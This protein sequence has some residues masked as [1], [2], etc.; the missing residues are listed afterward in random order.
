MKF[1]LDWL[2][3]PLETTASLEAI[4]EKL[5]AIGLEVESIE[6]KAKLL[7]PFTVAYVKEAKQH[8]DADRLR[9]CTVETGTEDLQIVCG[10]PNARAGIK[11][12]LSRPGDYIPGLDK[13]ISLGK[14]RGVESQG[15][16]C[17]ADE[18]GLGDDHDGIL[19][20]PADAPIGAKLLDVLA[21]IFPAAGTV[22]I[23]INLT[24]N[25]G[26]CAGV[27][28]IARDLAAAGLGKLKPL[29]STTVPAA[30]DNPYNVVVEDDADC[31]AIALRLI[32]GVKNIPSPSWLRSWLEAIGVTP[33]SALVDITNFLTFDL[34]RPLHVFD[35]AKVHGKTVIIRRAK[36]GESLEALN[37][38]TY[39][40]TPEMLVIADEQGVESLAGVMGGLASGCSENTTEVLVECALFNPERVAIAGRL[41]QINSD[42]R[43]RFERGVDPAS[44][45]YG[46]EI[47][48]RMILDICG[49][50]ASSIV[51]V[52]KADRNRDA[53]AYAPARF[54]KLTGVELAD[55]KQQ[56]VFEKLGCTVI[57]KGDS[58]QI[59]PPSW[60]PDITIPEDLIE[61]GLRIY[62]YDQIPAMP[63]PPVTSGT[64]LSPIQRR[65]A[66]ARRVATTQGLSECVTWSFMP[67]ALAAEFAPANPALAL[68]NPISVELSQ[69][70][71]SIVG[72]LLQTAARNA[73]H[74]QSDVA[75]FEVGPIYNQLGLDGQETVATGLRIG[76]TIPASW[77]MQA[78]PATLFTVKADLAALLEANGLSLD[79]VPLNRE[80]PSYY[81]PGRSFALRLGP[82]VI[83]YA[84][85]LHPRLVASQ[86]LK[87]AVAFELFL[88]RLPLPKK[89][90]AA[91][92]MLKLP[93]LQAVTRDFAFLVPADAPADALLK[94]IR[95]A[96]KDVITNVTLFDIYQDEARLPGQKSLTLTVTL[97]PRGDAAFTDKDLEAFSQKIVAAAE[98]TGAK[99]RS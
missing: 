29:P 66:L 1:T 49:G 30:F 83:A 11:V 34:A 2:K 50:E 9:V 67:P 45:T 46:M 97:Q 71:P 59:T 78:R 75:L 15:M 26:D 37:N 81:H 40:L 44:L 35:A 28:G 55:E 57:A 14:I 92:L 16:L 32:R 47:A 77:R 63:L 7:A 20:L 22:V 31:P 94:A 69:M 62:G 87:S 38:K 21:D 6:D 61:E 54:A 18:L 33:I 68:V 25:R 19:E 27:Y 70:R 95:K 85:E 42:A 41:L 82:T 84:G 64:A 60:R 86:D 48:T 58:W 13:T 93:V 65:T 43:Y 39:P 99:M 8:P 5:T 79:S 90:G 24:P 73:A 74:G 51:T 4:T 96:D 17:A 98:K 76:A 23:E 80:A 10:A 53:I 12:V 88:D 72:N 36:F 89:T 91:K 52:G 56:E 3:A